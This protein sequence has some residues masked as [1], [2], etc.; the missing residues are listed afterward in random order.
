MYLMTYINVQC[1]HLPYSLI[2]TLDLVSST[3]S[4]SGLVALALC[5]FRL[6]VPIKV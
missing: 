6:V 2:L 1:L 4:I 5:W 3:I